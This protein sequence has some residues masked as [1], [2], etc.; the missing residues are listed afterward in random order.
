L[1]AVGRAGLSHRK[2]LGEKRSQ[3]GEKKGL[4]FL[5]VLLAMFMVG[6]ISVYVRAAEENNGENLLVI[7]DRKLASLYI[8][9]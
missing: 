9:N 6:G 8:K 5:T 3:E 1:V 4:I 7:H 2:K